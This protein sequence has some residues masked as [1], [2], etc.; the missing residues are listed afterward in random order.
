MVCEKNSKSSETRTLLKVFKMYFFP[1]FSAETGS[2]LCEN[3][4]SRNTKDFTYYLSNISAKKKLGFLHALRH[5]LP[6]S[7]FGAASKIYDEVFCE[8]D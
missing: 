8:N 4:A 2:F 3:V 1:Q 5:A 7:V 6:G